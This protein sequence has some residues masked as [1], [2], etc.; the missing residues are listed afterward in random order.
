MPVQSV[1]FPAMADLQ[2]MHLTLRRQIFS[3]DFLSSRKNL[4]ALSKG[5]KKQSSCIQAL[6]ET[7][8]QQFRD[9]AEGLEFVEGVSQTALVVT[10]E[11]TDR[12]WR[13]G[14]RIGDRVMVGEGEKDL[15]EFVD[16]SVEFEVIVSV[17]AT[18]GK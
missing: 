2:Q 7:G 9:H 14:G 1:A 11:I 18:G 15:E 12:H 13:R 4:G 17:Y 10:V 8:G 6:L 3:V 5:V 16:Q